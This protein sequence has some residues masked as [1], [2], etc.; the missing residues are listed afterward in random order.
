MLLPGS[1]LAHLLS[2][3]LCWQEFHL[4]LPCSLFSEMS[5]DLVP[6]KTK[7]AGSALEF[8]MLLFPQCVVVTLLDLSFIDIHCSISIPHYLLWLGS[9]L[10][11]LHIDF[12]SKR[13]IG[14][15]EY[16]LTPFACLHDISDFPLRVRV[17]P[18]GNSSRAAHDYHHPV[19]QGGPAVQGRHA[20]RVVQGCR[21]VGAGGLRYV[22]E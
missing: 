2:P 16:N 10:F 15:F 22:Y 19:R 17:Q 1:L 4:D 8:L 13:S 14:P 12:E 21:G 11:R 3:C 9:L 7:I 20:A 18:L 5:P 6:D